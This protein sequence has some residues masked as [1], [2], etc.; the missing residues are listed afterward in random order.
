MS[1][2]RLFLDMDGTLA[3]FHDI[4]KMYMEAMWTQGF[5]TNL[6]PFENLVEGMKLFIGAHPEVEVYVLSAYLDTDPP[7]IVGEKDG[8]IEK[9]LPEIPSERRIFTRAGDNKADYIDGIGTNDYLMD[10]YNKN[11][12]EFEA[13]G[14]HGIKFRNDVNHQGIGAFGGDV[15]PLWD[16]H[17]IAYDM[18]PE[19]IAYNLELMI[20]Q[21]R[22]LANQLGIRNEEL[23]MKE[24]FTPE[25][26]SDL[27]ENTNKELKIDWVQTHTATEFVDW[28]LASFED[29][30]VSTY[31]EP[32]SAFFELFKLAD[33]GSVLASVT[34]CDNGFFE[35]YVERGAVG[36]EPGLYYTEKLDKAELVEL[37][38]KAINDISEVLIQN[39]KASKLGINEVFSTEAKS[40]SLDDKIADAEGEKEKGNSAALRH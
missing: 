26:K 5:Y 37:V 3:R 25:A 33:G 36:Q 12:F 1:K 38:Q 21:E 39:A 4:D 28:A 24:A 7:F 20:C 29:G 35:L 27:V 15:G 16:G 30:R 13:A 6:R 14:A 31:G 10:D 19:T 11:L 2:T 9:Y 32:Q 18:S 17:L 34:E 22:S 8:W 23:G 40:D